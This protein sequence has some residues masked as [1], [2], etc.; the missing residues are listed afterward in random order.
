MFGKKKINKEKEKDISQM[1]PE[2]EY[3]LAV[4]KFNLIENYRGLRSAQQIKDANWLDD[5]FLQ[6]RKDEEFKKWFHANKPYI[7]ELG[8]IMYKHFRAGAK[9]FEML[10]VGDDETHVAYGKR[11]FHRDFL[12]RLLK[13]YGYTV[14]DDLWNGKRVKLCIKYKD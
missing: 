9:M 6:R 10:Y 11:E 8:E 4:N 1:R 12:V 5:Y 7:D 14:M 2:S 13:N 3:E